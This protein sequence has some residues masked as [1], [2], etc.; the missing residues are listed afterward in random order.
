MEKTWGNLSEKEAGAIQSRSKKI[1]EKEI[2]DRFNIVDSSVKFKIYVKSDSSLAGK[3]DIN[4]DADV[5][6]EKTLP[7]EPDMVGSEDPESIEV[8]MAEIE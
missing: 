4:V 1:S 3:L 6:L 8:E 2:E 7:V 5:D